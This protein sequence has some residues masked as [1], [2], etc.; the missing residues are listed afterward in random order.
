MVDL[1]KFHPD[2]REITT[3]ATTSLFHISQL[4]QLL[5]TGGEIRTAI[6]RDPTLSLVLEKV[7]KGWSDEDKECQPYITKRYELSTSQGVLE[8]DGNN[9]LNPTRMDAENAACGTV[10]NSENEGTS[11]MLCVVALNR[12]RYWPHN[13]GM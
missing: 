2:S 3:F 10:G 13:Q 6:R 12:P 7:Q 5:V 11:L 1:V 4:E 9:L 8:N